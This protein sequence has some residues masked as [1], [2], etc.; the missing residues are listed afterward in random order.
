MSITQFT[1][2][3]D[4]MLDFMH[5]LCT[6][7]AYYIHKSLKKSKYIRLFSGSEFYHAVCYYQ[8]YYIDITGMYTSDEL[9]KHFE[10]YF[11]TNLTYVEPFSIK[12]L[13]NTDNE[14]MEEW[15]MDPQ[16]LQYTKKYSQLIINQFS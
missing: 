12:Y 2:P 5:G 11:H 1:F 3:N 13:P 4:V 8:G 6:P 9:Y 10:T 7:L 16:V 14:W 15:F